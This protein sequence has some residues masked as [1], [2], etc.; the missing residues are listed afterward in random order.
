MK[1]KKSENAGKTDLPV[2]ENTSEYGYEGIKSYNWLMVKQYLFAIIGA[3]VIMVIGGM[4]ALYTKE[5]SWGTAILK[6]FI[7]CTVV[8]GMIFALI[9]LNIKLTYNS[10]EKNG[11][12][13]S[14]E[15][16]F[17]ENRFETRTIPKSSESADMSSEKADNIDKNTAG[18]AETCVY[19]NIRRVLETKSC[20]VILLG[21][22]KGLYLK[23]NG[24]ESA[25][26]EVLKRNIKRYKR[27]EG[28]KAA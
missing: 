9:P 14:V 26:Y 15:S 7:A 11:K 1:I 8:Y 16:K 18:A 28:K 4:L 27:K 3:Y 5:Q 12:G 24:H 23:K 2:Y 13:F 17:Y 25:L 20:I 10:M 22:G 19:G 6:A 21:K